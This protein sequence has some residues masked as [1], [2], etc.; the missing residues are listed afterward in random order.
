MKISRRWFLTLPPT[1]AL[2]KAFQRLFPAEPLLWLRSPQVITY[3]DLNNA[4]DRAFKVSPPPS[5]FRLRDHVDKTY[6]KGII[7]RFPELENSKN[8]VCPNCEGSFLSDDGHDSNHFTR[9]NDGRIGIVRFDLMDS[10]E[11]GPFME[12]NWTPDSPAGCFHCKSYFS[13]PNLVKVTTV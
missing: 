6:L 1:A 13:L 3:T 9:L 8:I 4:Y 5:S 10:E 2:F 12:G 7:E 11:K